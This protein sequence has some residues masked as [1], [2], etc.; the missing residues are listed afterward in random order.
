M[1]RRFS[2]VFLAGSLL[3]A[4]SSAPPPQAFPDLRYNQ[5]PPIRLNV[6]AVRI[7]QAFQPTFA[8]PQVEQNF[9]IPPQRAVI[10]WVHDRL[11]STD[12]TSPLTARVTIQ[13]ASVREVGTP[14]NPARDD[15][16]VTD[17]NERYLG[18]TAVVIEILDAHDQPVR[19]ASAQSYTSRD[20]PAG[21]PLNTRDQMWYD[22]TRE[23][24]GN[25]AHDLEQQIESNF[26]PYD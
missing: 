13:D 20:V 2:T 19:S 22:M 25:L 11:Q 1:L 6:G 5:S 17:H 3:A 8:W 24:V 14:E 4:C 18:S 10:N 23:M 9:P 12:K 15:P 7:A 21:T 26:A 16:S